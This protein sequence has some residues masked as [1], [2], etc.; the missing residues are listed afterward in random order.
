MQTWATS[1]NDGIIN[2]YSYTTGNTWGCV[3][4]EL[5]AAGYYFDV[6]EQ[7]VISVNGEVIYK[8]YIPQTKPI[9]ARIECDTE[10]LLDFL[11]AGGDNQ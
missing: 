5:D 6:E 4:A 11:E 10:D 1:T 9:P 8:F 3:S 7:E 2:G